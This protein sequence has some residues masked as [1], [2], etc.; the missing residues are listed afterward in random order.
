MDEGAIKAVS[1]KRTV[2][3]STEP[4]GRGEG[5]ECG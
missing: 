4:G 1:L 3:H 5:D 2:I